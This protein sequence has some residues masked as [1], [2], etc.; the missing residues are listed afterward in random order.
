MFKIVEIRRISTGSIYKLFAIGFLCSLLPLCM[1]MGLC[2]VFGAGTVSWNGSPVTGIAGLFASPF[3]GAFLCAIFVAVY[4]SLC[5]LG[6][7]IYSRF[8]TF[9]IAIQEFSDRDAPNAGA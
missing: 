7:W 2:S 1:L 8:L 9:T 3:I 5:A 4:G 6:L